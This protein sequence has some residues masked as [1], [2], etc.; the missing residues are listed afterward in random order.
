M[1]FSVTLLCLHLCVYMEAS[2]WHVSVQVSMSV[3]V[4]VR[5]FCMWEWWG[6]DVCRLPNP[7]DKKPWGLFL[8]RPEEAGLPQ[9]PWL[10]WGLCWWRGPLSSEEVALLWSDQGLLYHYNLCP[11]GQPAPGKC[12][13]AEEEAGAGTALPQSA[14]S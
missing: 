3:P 7:S 8:K 13:A 11:P 4:C 6:V 2:E 1:C 14:S 10:G 9:G 12:R 5:G